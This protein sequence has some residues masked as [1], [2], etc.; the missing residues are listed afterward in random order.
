M[1]FFWYFISIIRAVIIIILMVVWMLVYLVSLLFRRHT[2][3]AALALRTHYLKW[4]AFPFLG[5]EVEI[6]GKVHD[7]PAM[8]V[9]NHRS[10]SDPLIICRWL[11]A[12]VVAK[13]EVANYPIINK[14]AEL[15]GVLYVKREEKDS[16][17]NVRKM[18][19]DTIRSGYNILIFPEGTV[20]T[21]EKTLD[22]K[23]GAFAAVLEEDIPIIP[24]AIEYKSPKDLWLV[25]N[26]VQQFIIMFSKPK[27]YVR[28][29]IGTPLHCDETD[30][31]VRQSQKWIDDQ[32]EDMQRN[33][34]DIDFNRYC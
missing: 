34:S 12:F 18:I 15:T 21:K 24:V 19:I 23:K 8:Y 14:G 4:V 22:F 31:C 9:S 33:W 13:A 27:T 32:L 30:E 20:G 26:F 5:F 1:S 16:R 2:K 6:E 3:T 7:I 10:F 29:R 25:N 28:L 11:R 17:K